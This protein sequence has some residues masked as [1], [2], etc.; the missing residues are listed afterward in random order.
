MTPSW[1]DQTRLTPPG[2]PAVAPPPDSNSWEATAHG[3]PPDI[4][5][6]GY[7]AIREKFFYQNVAP[8]VLSKG[9]S[10]SSAKDAFMSST[11]RQKA[12]FPRTML[13]A[14]EAGKAATEPISAMSPVQGSHAIQQSINQR[15]EEARIEAAKQGIWTPPY[16][17]AGQALGMA[18]YFAEGLMGPEAAGEEL[19]LKSLPNAGRLITEEGRIVL[20]KEATHA[21]E[22]YN[23]SLIKKATTSSAVGLIQGSYDAAVA[24]E[25]QKGQAFVQGA[26]TGAALT[27]GIEGVGGLWSY[28]RAGHGLEEDSARAVERVAKGVGDSRDEGLATRA[29][30]TTA[31]LD[32][33]VEG[34]VTEQKKAKVRQGVPEDVGVETPPADKPAGS[35]YTPSGRIRIQMTGADGKNYWLGGAVGLKAEEFEKIGARVVEHLKAGGSVQGIHGDPELVNSTL[36]KLVELNPDAFSVSNPL[37]TLGDVKAPETVPASAESLAAEARASIS[38]DRRFAVNPTD[39]PT[40]DNFVQLPNGEVMNRATG[41]VHSNLQEASSPTPL[42]YKDTPLSRRYV[43][44]SDL[45]PEGVDAMTVEYPGQE[46][47]AIFYRDNPTKATIFHENLHGHFGALNMHGIVQDVMDDSM[48]DQIFHAGFAPVAKDL[49]GEDPYIWR[50]EVYAH[51]ADAIRTANE[52]KINSFAEADD[53]KDHYLNWMAEKTNQLLDHIASKDDS[54]HKR[55]AERRLSSVLTRSTNS[56]AD[57]QTTFSQASE[58]LD[59]AHGQYALKT[60]NKATL[61]ASREEALQALEAQG[62]PLNSPELIPTDRL[63]DGTP[64]YARSVKPMS[65]GERP[66]STD[67][68]DPTLNSGN[69]GRQARGGLQLASRFFRPFNDWVATVSQ[70]N[71]WP[72]LWDA[73][74]PLDGAQVAFNNTVRPYFEELKATLG[75]LPESRQKD[76]MK[77]FAHPEDDFIKQELH[78]TSADQ[79]MLDRVQTNVFDPLKSEFGT[80]LGLE[81]YVRSRFLIPKDNFMM[82]RLARGSIDPNEENL[83]KLAAKY[84]EFGAFD[85]HVTPAID[86]AEEVIKEQMPG[87]KGGAAYQGRHRDLR[88]GSLY[89]LLQRHIDYLRGQPDYTQEIVK[90]A[91]EGAVELINKGLSKLGFEKQ[92]SRID[93][94]PLGKYTLFMYAGALAM[95]PATIVRD[96]LQLMLT[97]YPVAGKYTFRGLEKAFGMATKGEREKLWSIPQKYG[98]L[99]ERSDLKSLYDGSVAGDEVGSTSHKLMANAEKMANW[100]MKSIQLTHNGNRLAAFWGHSEQV[101]DALDTFRATGDQSRFTRDSGLWFM[102]PSMRED[103]LREIPT[104]SKES[105]ADFSYRAAKELTELSQWNF[106]RGANPGLYEYQLGRLFGQYG[107]WPLNYI[108]YGRRLATSGDGRSA[109]EAITRLALAHG[110]ILA[111]GQSMGVDTG[112]W[113]FT[114]PM[115]YEGGPLF[116][117]VTSASSV[118]EPGQTG[119][120]ARHDVV[121]LIPGLDRAVEAKDLFEDIT[122]GA[123]HSW[124][125]ILGFHAAREN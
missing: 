56:L 95:K 84:L 57:I 102:S 93:E 16:Q 100:G 60:Q 80:A 89:P 28:L 66:N 104:L 69:E 7:N 58:T 96:G 12:D 122:S 37:R 33:S 18:P 63:L 48:A 91:M 81:D 115:A 36:N 45:T 4:P 26:A 50:E 65:S 46:K 106:K 64:R 92:I 112:R 6:S 53:G 30:L 125:K 44:E 120:D 14:A 29:V 97:T 11:E 114:G 72:E 41:Q 21:L 43:G 32:K 74:H 110:A 111:A 119:R 107:T 78:W 99:I 79:A 83:A 25:G 51:G 9:M 59:F 34:F 70:K 39:I 94:D 86:A 77:V 19:A 82:K 121:G 54:L 3:L 73:F 8:Q 49:Y 42:Q 75:T 24:P 98:A 1:L 118:A 62:E 35:V 108:E 13:V 5:D 22:V 109:G 15:A 103:F 116:N 55:A 123:E 10:L 31:D 68:A 85:K 113:V 38:P 2:Q 20:S 47:P 124:L 117:A 27:A 76:F 88:A 87:S 105:H 23:K 52:E 61:Y 67:P 40:Y 90:G 101:L 71:S 17:L